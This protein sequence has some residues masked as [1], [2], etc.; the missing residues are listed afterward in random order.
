MANFSGDLPSPSLAPGYSL[1]T[2]DVPGVCYN[3]SNKMWYG[4][5][6]DKLDKKLVGY[7]NKK[8][9]TPNFNNKAD[10]E[11]ACIALR[12]ELDAKFEATTARWAKENELTR[13]LPRGAEDIA[14]AEQGVAYWRPNQK[15][16]YRPN[17]M[18][19]MMNAS[20]SKGAVWISA[21]QHPGCVMQPEAPGKG[22]KPTLC[23]PHGGGCPH[24]QVWQNCRECNTRILKM[25]RCCGTCGS[26]LG[27]KRIKKNGGNGLCCHCEEKVNEE[28][29]ANGSAPP[30]K[31]KRWEDVVLDSVQA[32][33]STAGFPPE[34]RDDFSSMLGSNKRRRYG[35]CDTE[36]QSRP[37]ILF[38][39][40][41]RVD[42][43]IIAALLVEV[44]ENSHSDRTS[45]CELAR[46]DA[47][48]E[49][50]RK[51]AQTEGAARGAA[52]REYVTMPVLLVL[53]INPNSFDSK[54]AVN[55]DKRVEALVARSLAFLR[56]SDEEFEER[57]HDEEAMLPSVRC[58]FY[59]SEQGSKHLAAYA[60]A[61]AD[62]KLVYMGNDR[63]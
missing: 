33:L 32:E 52:A 3:K 47:I 17:K 6:N 20:M 21:C 53:R 36:T 42:A 4:R 55:L 39:K 11:E 46:V 54:P 35:E 61:H 59:H 58:M 44:D 7:G 41:D 63:K 9:N 48:L 1:H 13:G 8:V 2:S 22:Q 10:A 28:A 12:A 24:K 62:K 40:R 34:S 38:V 14:K 60:A 43:R 30:P 26:I 15:D 16:G 23:V 31:S 56:I 19:K 18:T 51:L 27:A 50:L 37:D 57:S 5:V 29:N 45:Q 49:S 25:A